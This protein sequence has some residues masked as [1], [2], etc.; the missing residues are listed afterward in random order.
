MAET[1]WTKVST[2]FITAMR[3]QKLTPCEISIATFLY[4]RFFYNAKEPKC[5]EFSSYSQF[6][7]GIFNKSD[8]KPQNFGAG[9]SR[10]TLANAV[11]HNSRLMQ[12]FINR[13]YEQNSK[14]G[15]CYYWQFENGTGFIPIPNFMIDWIMPQLRHV[16][17][18]IYLFIA[19]KNAVMA[20]DEHKTLLS[21]SYLMQQ[22]GLS[23]ST[24]KR[25]IR[26]LL[27]LGI[28]ARQSNGVYKTVG[29]GDEQ[30]VKLALLAAAPQADSQPHIKEQL[31]DQQAIDLPV[32]KNDQ[33]IFDPPTSLFLT[34]HQS[35]S[36][37]VKN[38]H[39]KESSLNDLLENSLSIN[40]LLENSLQPQPAKLSDSQIE[41]EIKAEAKELSDF[42]IK[43]DVIIEARQSGHR[44]SR[45][46]GA[47]Q[48]QR[49]QQALLAKAKEW[50]EKIGIGN[51]ATG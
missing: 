45:Q 36:D 34:P 3:K 23:E 28:I 14:K 13:D 46:R 4:R 41:Q 50:G 18:W 51:Q 32:E 48:L 30:A 35:I 19:Y 40:H 49:E 8:G 42:T 1:H 16:E 9:V 31:I 17:W 7:D 44:R 6:T 38:R 10:Q 15:N 33:S 2:N 11:R 27:K 39:T 43:S 22:L 20:K 21:H 12:L 26:N 24:I 5:T 47:E 29:A 37:P 25:S